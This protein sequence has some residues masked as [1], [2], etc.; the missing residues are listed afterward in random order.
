MAPSPLS[1]RDSWSLVEAPVAFLRRTD[2]TS[3]QPGG[4]RSVSSAARTT[5]P[6]T[7]AQRAGEPRRRARMVRRGLLRSPAP[8]LFCAPP[9]KAM[10]AQEHVHEAPRAWQG[11]SRQGAFTVYLR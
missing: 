6:G 7:G 4:R 10:W 3:G 11:L 5:F 2:P 1:P 8:R 9:P